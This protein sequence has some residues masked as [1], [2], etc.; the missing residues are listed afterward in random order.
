MNLRI[1]KALADELMKIAVSANQMQGLQALFKSKPKVKPWLQQ[2]QR[3]G[4]F[5]FSHPTVAAFQKTLKP[6]GQL[7]AA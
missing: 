4:G 3:Q 7:V 2:I 6:S 1:Y 5:Q